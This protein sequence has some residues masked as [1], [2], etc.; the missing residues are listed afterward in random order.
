VG[1]QDKLL[2]C[3]LPCL[4]LL[5]TTHHRNG[6]PNCIFLDNTSRG[7]NYAIRQNHLRC[8]CKVGNATLMTSYYHSQWFATFLC[9]RRYIAQRFGIVAIFVLF[10][11]FPTPYHY[12][13]DC[14]YLFLRP[15]FKNTWKRWMTP[16]L[17]GQ[18]HGFQPL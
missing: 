4:R 18:T 14:S 15:A 2:H 16:L 5:S 8:C 9:Y 17:T 13:Y 11:F 12:S 10:L 6:I 1:F 7:K 3:K